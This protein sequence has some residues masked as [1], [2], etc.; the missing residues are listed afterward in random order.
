MNRSISKRV[1]KARKIT[2]DAARRKRAG[3]VRGGTI[4]NQ[5]KAEIAR[6]VSEFQAKVLAELGPNLSTAKSTEVASLCAAYAVLL[7]L[8]ARSGYGARGAVSA[9]RELVR[10]IPIVERTLTALELKSSRGDA[11][12]GSTR[13]IRYLQDEL[14]RVTVELHGER[15]KNAAPARIGGDPA[16]DHTETDEAHMELHAAGNAPTDDDSETEQESDER[17]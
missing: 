6:L 10:V 13:L 15:L 14:Q 2:A 4:V 9:S 3:Q 1:R 8:N 11:D 16:N 17:R 7:R 5:R 12:N